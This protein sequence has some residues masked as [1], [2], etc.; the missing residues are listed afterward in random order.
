MSMRVLPASFLIDLHFWSPGFVW[1]FIFVF[2]FVWCLLSYLYFQK[3]RSP[4]WK[5][6]LGDLDNHRSYYHHCH[7]DQRFGQDRQ[8]HGHQT[9]LLVDRWRS[10]RRV[11]WSGW[12]PREGFRRTSQP[13]RKKIVLKWKVFGIL[14]FRNFF[15]HSWGP[16]GQISCH[17]E[18]FAPIPA[19]VKYLVAI[20]QK[21]HYHVPL[22]GTSE[23]LSRWYPLMAVKLGKEVATS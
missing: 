12:S 19:F 7:H 11:G 21:V 17:L 3:H 4:G 23:D 5:K 15:S 18:S 8:D 13:G 6:L 22:K 16:W 20:S 14:Y 10:C 1:C 2:L 9:H